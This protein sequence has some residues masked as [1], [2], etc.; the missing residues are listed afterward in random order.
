LQ[1]RALIE[2]VDVVVG[3]G[4]GLPVYAETGK[5]Q[6]QILQAR[7]LIEVMDAVVGVGLG[8]QRMQGLARCKCRYVVHLSFADVQR[9]QRLARCKRRHVAYFGIAEVRRLLVDWLL[10][11]FVCLVCLFVRLVGWLVRAAWV[12]I[13]RCYVA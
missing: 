2:V 7:A 12:R 6:V 9:V 4:A 8:Y 13:A 3:V 1:T 11:L 5:M 10:Y